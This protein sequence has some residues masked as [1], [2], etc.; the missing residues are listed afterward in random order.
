MVSV[1]TKLIDIR[2]TLMLVIL[3]N[4]SIFTCKYKETRGPLGPGS[5]T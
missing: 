5:L 4:D 2:Y 3:N 1:L